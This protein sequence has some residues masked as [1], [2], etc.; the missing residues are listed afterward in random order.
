MA[1]DQERY[2]DYVAERTAEN[3][4]PCSRFGCGEPAWDISYV[5]FLCDRHMAET[6]ADYNANTER[7]NAQARRQMEAGRWNGQ[8]F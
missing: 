7:V 4:M 2:G 5:V 6:D 3:A 1:T 8:D